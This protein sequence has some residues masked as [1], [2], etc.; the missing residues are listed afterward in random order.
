MLS[1]GEGSLS[2]QETSVTAQ[3]RD[4]LEEEKHSENAQSTQEISRRLE[5]L[6]QK[7]ETHMEI[8]LSTEGY[9]DEVKRSF[10]ELPA[11]IQDIICYRVWHAFGKIEGIHYDF[12]RHSYL[13][14]AGQLN[15]AYFASPEIRIQIVCALLDELRSL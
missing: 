11:C 9:S 7:V 6:A 12:G 8:L 15:E 4:P 2:L 10:E 1:Y 5:N 3:A 14:L 13:H